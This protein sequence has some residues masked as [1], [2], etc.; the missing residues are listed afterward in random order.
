M[1]ALRLALLN[2]LRHRLTTVLVIIAIALPVGVGGLLLRFYHLSQTRFAT[3]D[4]SFDIVV[5]A[6]SG[7]IDLLLNSLN[8][9][10]S[11]PDF[12]PLT[13]FDTI[14]ARHYHSDLSLNPKPEQFLPDLIPM[15]IFGRFEGQRLLGTDSSYWRPRFRAGE[16]MAHTPQFTAGRP[17]QAL[18]EVAI[19]AKVAAEHHLTMG[20]TIIATPWISPSDDVNRQLAPFPLTVVG[21]IAPTGLAWDHQLFADLTEAQRVLAGAPYGHLHPVWRE[22][23][24]HFFLANNRGGQDQHFKELRSLIN[25][26]TVAQFISVRE[27]LAR[28]ED[29]TGTSHAVGLVVTALILVLGGVGVAGIMIMRSDTLIHQ[30]AVLRALGYPQTQLYGW[31]LWEGLMLGTAAVTCGAIVDAL[32][33]PWLQR[34]THMDAL[35]S[36]SLMSSLPVWGLALAVTG[37]ATCFPLLRLARKN[38]HAALRD[39]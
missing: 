12:F 39:P 33:F 9:E 22:N 34:I 11:Y 6:K 29:L 10:G 19:G 17:P 7:E 36:V 21:M 30:L 15:V 35:P 13:M 23:V 1:T 25:Q 16:G 27:E 37:C 14:R 3:L 31:L 8:G 26:A 2:L 5:G 32:D 4:R 38:I 28:L 24:L 18:G 20:A